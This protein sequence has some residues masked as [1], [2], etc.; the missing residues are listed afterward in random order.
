MP[1]INV[2]VSHS[3]GGD[4]LAERITL[5]VFE[6]LRTA[7]RNYDVKLDKVRLRPGS[8][9]YPQLMSWIAECDVAVVFLNAAALESTW[10][11]R[12]VNILMWRRSLCPSLRVLP[13]LIGEVTAE[14]LRQSGF[15]EL[16]PL[17]YDK[18]PYS[19]AD[20]S[21]A[22]R[23]VEEVLGQFA[24][25][26]DVRH[27]TDHMR[28][29]IED[30]ARLLNTIH[31][32][33]ALT[34]TG[35]ALGIREEDLPQIAAFAGGAEFLAHHMLAAATVA[36]LRDAVHE[37]ARSMSGSP[38]TDLIALLTPTWIDAAAARRLLPPKGL[39]SKRLVALNARET[40]TAGQ[41]VDRA[42]CRRIK[43]YRYQTAGGIPVG[44]D[45]L[46]DFVTQCVEAVRRVLYLSARKKP[47]DFRPRKDYLHCL[48][49]DVHEVR[50]RLVE[51]IVARVHD[52]FPWLVIV[53][54]ADASDPA[55]TRLSPRL[56]DLVILPALAEEDEDLGYQLTQE[57]MD[58]PN[59]RHGQ[60][61][62]A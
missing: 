16:L 21:Y 6:G 12:E 5:R 15:E 51:R 28:C 10:V 39:A 24:E 61:V 41:Y 57:L 17:Q 9:W 38:L 43:F 3:F 31:D 52:L 62:S 46:D 36:G 25:L 23:L 11:R 13:V 60:E 45:A 48:I 33:R 34:A 8:E 54:L 2:F 58:L 14:Q 27:E 42:M 7:A 26:P 20:R 1:M 53:L 22:D 44:E 32:Q 35:R 18:V 30:V 55:R 4:P 29:W 59:R 40:E 37:I 49:L 56:A 47:Q 19:A 50:P